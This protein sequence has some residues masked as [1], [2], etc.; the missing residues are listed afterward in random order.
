[1]PPGTVGCLGYTPI[2]PHSRY[3]IPNPV[4]ATTPLR[5]P[6]WFRVGKPGNYWLVFFYT[7]T[8]RPGTAPPTSERLRVA[9][10][11]LTVG[12]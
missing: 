10:A 6:G 7:F 11:K 1:L 8:N 12:R 2:A 4:G 9:Y 5:K 3:R